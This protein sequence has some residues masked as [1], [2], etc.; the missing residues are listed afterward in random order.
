M[1]PLA[2]AALP[3]AMKGVLIGM[4]WVIGWFHHKIVAAKAAHAPLA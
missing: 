3:Y 2:V 4:G 1:I